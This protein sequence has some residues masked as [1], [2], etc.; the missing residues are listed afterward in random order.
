MVVRSISVFVFLLAAAALIAKGAVAQEKEPPAL[1]PFGPKETTREDSVPGYLELSDSTVHP[2]QIFLTR[3]H[4]LSIFDVKEDRLRQVPLQAIRRIDCK[5]VKEWMEDEWRFKENANDQKVFTGRAYPAREYL[6]IITLTSGRKIEGPLAG[7]VYVAPASRPR[8]RA[9]EAEGEGEP[10]ARFL[11]H[12][13][14]KGEIGTE[15]RSLLYVRSICLGAS[16]L[17]EGQKKAV[18]VQ[19]GKNHRGQ[20]SGDGNQGPEP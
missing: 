12:K 15:L 5:V 19:P 16:A 7:I 20:E 18:K 6:H 1:D 3:D 2:G 10:A 8:A 13:R 17:E 9:G 14:D 4:R 11:L